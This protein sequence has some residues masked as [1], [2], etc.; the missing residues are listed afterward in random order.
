MPSYC[1]EPRTFRSSHQPTAP[2]P[3]LTHPSW[4][5]LVLSNPT[6]SFATEPSWVHSVNQAYN[7]V[8]IGKQINRAHSHAIFP[9]KTFTNPFFSLTRF[10]APT[11][12]TYADKM[13]R[14]VL[15]KL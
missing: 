8:T 3:N 10:K 5:T 4:V 15:T 13:H 7:L 11:S 2:C 12:V 9:P 6:F 14:F 1:F